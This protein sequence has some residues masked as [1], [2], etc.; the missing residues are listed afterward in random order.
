[1]N[2]FENFSDNMKFIA[3]LL[4]TNT[5]VIVMNMNTGVYIMQKTMVMGGLAVG[6]EVVKKKMKRRK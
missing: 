3:C 5:A 4:F 1:M 6:N 2:W